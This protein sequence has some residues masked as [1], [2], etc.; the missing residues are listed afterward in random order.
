MFK[1]KIGCTGKN[2]LSFCGKKIQKTIYTKI[3]SKLKNFDE[4]KS[5][6]VVYKTHEKYTFITKTFEFL[7]NRELSDIEYNLFI[8]KL[9]H[10]GFSSDNDTNIQLINTKLNDIIFDYKF[11]SMIKNKP[12]VYIQMKNKSVYITQQ[13]YKN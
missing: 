4:I 6:Q 8:A 12:K 9:K 1:I 11:S 5:I 3:I 2:D 10:A 13:I 7:I